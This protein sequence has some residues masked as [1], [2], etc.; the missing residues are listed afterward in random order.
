MVRGGFL[1]LC[2]LER[3]QLLLGG[4]P[5]IGREPETGELRAKRRYLRGHLRVGT[6][7]VTEL[8]I[9]SGDR[10]RAASDV[11]VARAR[12]HRTGHVAEP[13][14]VVHAS[15]L[16]CRCLSRLRAAFDIP[17]PIPAMTPPMR[18]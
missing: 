17:L 18:K 5:L 6:H 14:C 3:V 16:R 2:L 12:I 8:E 4:A 10:L 9:T 1:F 11:H 15:L 7:A 13:E